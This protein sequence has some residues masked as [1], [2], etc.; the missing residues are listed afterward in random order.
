[1]TVVTHNS[2]DKF[3]FIVHTSQQ[4]SA[5]DYEEATETTMTE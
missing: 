5:E 2:V 4:S 3:V 1:M